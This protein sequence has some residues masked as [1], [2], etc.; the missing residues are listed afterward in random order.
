MNC[1]LDTKVKV[2]IFVVISL[3]E[4]IQENFEDTISASHNHQEVHNQLGAGTTCQASLW[5][6]DEAIIVYSTKETT[7]LKN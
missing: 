2:K 1:V 5:R 4:I 6:R 3:V 7:S